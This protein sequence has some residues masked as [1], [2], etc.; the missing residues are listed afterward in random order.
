[1][2]K[3]L[4]RF[5]RWFWPYSFGIYV[6]CIVFQIIW[7]HSSFGFVIN[8]F[9][10]VLSVV[11]FRKKTIEIKKKQSIIKTESKKREEIIY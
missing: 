3:F 10:I 2:E 9:W 8:I 5:P 1:M 6:L 7:G 11:M 4:L